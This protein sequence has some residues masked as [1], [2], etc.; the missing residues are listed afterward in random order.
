MKWAPHGLIHAPT[1]MNHFLRPFV[2]N[3]KKNPTLSRAILAKV[4]SHVLQILI[5]KGSGGFR[6]FCSRP[7]LKMSDWPLAIFQAYLLLIGPH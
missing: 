5:L 2:S 1:G 6:P 3:V 4:I 7:P